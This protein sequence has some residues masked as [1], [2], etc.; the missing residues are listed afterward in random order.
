MARKNRRDE[1][2]GS[3][4]TSAATSSGQEMP[5]EDLG[6]TVGTWKGMPRYQCNDCPFDSLNLLTI[7]T[8]IEAHRAPPA[9]AAPQAIQVVD[10]WGNPVE[11]EV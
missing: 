7:L 3:P 4:D 9:P 6:Y 11:R 8:H 10:R 1:G 2:T 5:A